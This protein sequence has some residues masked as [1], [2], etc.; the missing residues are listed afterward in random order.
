MAGWLGWTHTTQTTRVPSPGTR[1][2]CLVCGGVWGW[3]IGS[4]RSHHFSTR[5]RGRGE[6]HDAA[7]AAAALVSITIIIIIITDTH[8]RRR[9]AWL[10]D[11]INMAKARACIGYYMCIILWRITTTRAGSSWQRGRDGMGWDMM[12]GLDG[13]MGDW[14]NEG[15]WMT[16]REAGRVHGAAA[17]SPCIHMMYAVCGY[18]IMS[19]F[20]PTFH[21]SC[22]LF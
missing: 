12:Q 17:A 9:G 1:P 4:R 7:A 13:M 5:G 11:C 21:C 20:S 10:I 18:G 8:E 2:P 16:L 15:F 22:V 3:N 19:I 14:K 6:G